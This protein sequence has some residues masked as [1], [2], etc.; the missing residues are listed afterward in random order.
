MLVGWL[1]GPPL[2]M[3]CQLLVFRGDIDRVYPP[4]FGMVAGSLVIFCSWNR[5]AR[6]EL[7]GLLRSGVI[8]TLIG[9]AAGAI[10]GAAVYPPLREAIGPKANLFAPDEAGELDRAVGVFLAE[11]PGWLARRVRTLAGTGGSSTPVLR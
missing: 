9:M 11:S 3:G 2:D 8:G 5:L 1:V 10:L 6:I 7:R 4:V